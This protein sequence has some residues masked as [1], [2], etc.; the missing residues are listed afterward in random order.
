[1]AMKRNELLKL[2]DDNNIQEG[3]II[4]EVMAHIINSFLAENWDNLSGGKLTSMRSHKFDRHE[5]L[6]Y[7][8]PYT[9]V[10]CIERH[11]GIKQ[12][13]KYAEIQEWTIDIQSMVAECKVVGSR[14]KTPTDKRLSQHDIKE[15]VDKVVTVV[16]NQT[17][18]PCVKWISSDKVK[19]NV[20]SL[21]PEAN[22]QTTLGRR[23]RFR[24]TL[25]S[26]LNIHGW[27]ESSANIF[28]R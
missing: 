12:G 1:M 2:L 5:G 24:N 13:S 4:D 17:Q 3:K 22:K 21:I 20:G 25:C 15:L 8:P 10:F 26:E 14:L 7:I 23:K 16:L 6:S 9:I 28:V 18:D 19:I 11:G 27:H